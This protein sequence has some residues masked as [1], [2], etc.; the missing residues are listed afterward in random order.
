[1]V[2]DTKII[3]VKLFIRFFAG[4]TG[5]DQKAIGVSFRWDWSAGNSN[6]KL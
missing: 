5:W 3:F 6:K 1:M 2:F 4:K